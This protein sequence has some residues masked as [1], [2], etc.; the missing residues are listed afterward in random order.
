MGSLEL[1]SFRKQTVNS[2][3]QSHN[4]TPV[5]EVYLDAIHRVHPHVSMNKALTFA[6]CAAAVL[7]LSQALAVEPVR[8]DARTA[9]SGNWSDPKT[10]ESG[11]APRAGDFVQVRSNHFVVY[12][13]QSDAALR[14]VHV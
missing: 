11:R 1:P 7:L 8:F 13:V 2:S 14:M 4:E 9:T 5:R 6:S 12:D 3:A 10:W